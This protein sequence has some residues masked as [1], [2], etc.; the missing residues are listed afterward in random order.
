MRAAAPSSPLVD[1]LS[2]RPLRP[3]HGGLWPLIERAVAGVRYPARPRFEE[4]WGVADRSGRAFWEGLVDAG[5][6]PPSWLHDDSRGFMNSRGWLCGLYRDAARPGALHTIET[7]K[8]TYLHVSGGELPPD[9]LPGDLLNRWGEGF[10]SA[11]LP[12]PDDVRLAVAMASDVGNVELAE[13]LAREA[14]ERL[15]PWGAQEVTRVGWWMMPRGQGFGAHR[16]EGAVDTVTSSVR[17]AFDNRPL[18]DDGDRRIEALQWAADRTKRLPSLATP[19][20]LLSYAT[21]ALRWEI[22]AEERTPVAWVVGGSGPLVSP[23]HVLRGASYDDFLNPFVPLL[24]VCAL[25]YSLRS[26]EGPNYLLFTQAPERPGG[27]A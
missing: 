15:I 14:A 23:P 8:N 27:G 12:Q 4:A 25:G 13:S 7:S 22:L 19:S 11:L 6:V 9:A 24:E 5:L 2:G 16:H 17:W 26:P 10:V 1:F 18:P 21:A 3:N 20:E